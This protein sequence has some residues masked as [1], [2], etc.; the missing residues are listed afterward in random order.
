MV[1]M[2]VALPL[3]SVIASALLIYSAVRSGGDDAIADSV[4]RTAQIQVSDLGPDQAA[5]QRQLS[6]VLRVDQGLV[7][8]LPASGDFNRAA[9]LSLSLRH[10]TRAADDRLIVL[11]PTGNGWRARLVL[12]GTHDWRLLVAPVDGSWRILGRL[13][14]GQ[15]AARLAPVLATP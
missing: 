12:D 7:E 15:R 6:A 11:L 3:A 9:P 4:Q 5:A 2:L 14:K 8:L 1:W 13:P 10:P